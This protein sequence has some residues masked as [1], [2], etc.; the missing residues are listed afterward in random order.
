VAIRCLCQLVDW[1]LLGAALRAEQER[2]ACRTVVARCRE[3]GT[4]FT[5][6]RPAAGGIRSDHGPTMALWWPASCN[7]DGMNEAIWCV[8][9]GLFWWLVALM[10]PEK[11]A[12]WARSGKDGEPRTNADTAQDTRIPVLRHSPE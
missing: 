1:V 10:L 11:A 8:A 7:G 3:W 9:Y 4:K 2:A 12:H 6:S 5:G